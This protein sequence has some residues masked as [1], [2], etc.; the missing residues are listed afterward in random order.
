MNQLRD[1]TIAVYEMFISEIIWTKIK[2][3]SDSIKGWFKNKHTHRFLELDRFSKV[4]HERENQ[5]DWS[6]TKSAIYGFKYSFGVVNCFGSNE[7][8][9][10][11]FIVFLRDI[12]E[13]NK[14][15]QKISKTSKIIIHL[16]IFYSSVFFNH[17]IL[18]ER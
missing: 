3:P 8:T 12:Y 5:I 14:K 10:F 4:W 15:L 18:H 7:I 6:Q 9:Y 11:D 17:W 16:S 1:C 2:L 13:R